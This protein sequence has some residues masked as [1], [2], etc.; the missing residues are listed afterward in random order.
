MSITRRRFGGLMGA[1]LGVTALR[2]F[3]LNKKSSAYFSHGVASGDP[4][5]DRVILWTRVLP[6]DG[7][8]R[9]LNVE[10]QVAADTGFVKI[11]SS[12]QA[13]TDISRDFTDKYDAATQEPGS[14]YFYRFI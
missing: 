4:L 3:A 9:S 11:V 2:G 14:R 7:F 10:W 1:S 8:D 13:F 12:G 6:G 5:K